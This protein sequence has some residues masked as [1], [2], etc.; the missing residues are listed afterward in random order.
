VVDGVAD[1]ALPVVVHE[2]DVGGGP[3]LDLGGGAGHAV[4]AA[5]EA[6]QPLQ[7]RIDQGGGA[8][9]AGDDDQ[10]S[11]AAVVAQA[12][13]P[14]QA[15]PVEGGLKDLVEGFAQVCL[16]V[17]IALGSGEPGDVDGEQAAH[18]FVG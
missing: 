18:L 9:G 6:A 7:E 13:V 17:V 2:A 14:G 1:E 3:Q 5:D 10:G 15:G 8:D 4:V 11:V 16:D 12:L